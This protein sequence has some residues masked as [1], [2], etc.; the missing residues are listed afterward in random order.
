MRH[1]TPDAFAFD[2]GLHCVGSQVCAGVPNS[3]GQAGTLCLSGSTV[4]VA[5]LLTAVVGALPPQTFGLLVASSE[6][7]VVANPG[8]SQGNLYIDGPSLGRYN[9]DIFRGRTVPYKIFPPG[10]GRGLLDL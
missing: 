8:G 10:T 6:F 3:T 9:A 1:R 7:G 4:A 5:N 2:L